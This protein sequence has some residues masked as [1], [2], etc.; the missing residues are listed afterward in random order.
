MEDG[1]AG[2]AVLA[3][4]LAISLVIGV[5]H[6][7]LKWVILVAFGIRAAAALTHVFML[8]LPGSGDDVVRYEALGW[9][10]A[11]PG[12]SQAFYSFTTGPY[13]YS[14]I[15]GMVY[16]WAGRSPLA[17]QGINVIFGM[18][19]VFATFLLARQLGSTPRNSRRASWLAS[20]FPEAILYSALTAR[21]AIPILFVV[22]GSYSIAKWW[23]GLQP[24]WLILA[25][26]SFAICSFFHTGFIVLFGMIL[27]VLIVRLRRLN[28]EDAT[29]KVLASVGASFVVIAVA[30]TIALTGAGLEKLQLLDKGLDDLQEGKARDRAAYLSGVTLQKPTDFIWQPPLRLAHFFFAPFPWQI[31]NMLDVLG[32]LDAM[33]YLYLAYTI[34]SAKSGLRRNSVALLISVLV[35]VTVLA[36]S[37]A[38]SNYGAAIR[39]RAKFAFLLLAIYAYAKPFAGKKIRRFLRSHSNPN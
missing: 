20:F 12:C 33:F 25:T 31:Q 24:R 1:L 7:S 38:T 2:T 19:A 5:R 16:C 15:I 28:V 39:H 26:V 14:W 29:P 23:M 27:P 36:F 22:L 18:L 30:L 35:L 10:F 9:S 34:V 21:E 8:A 32:A 17:I 37:M 6:P 3:L 4:G 11:E 13:L